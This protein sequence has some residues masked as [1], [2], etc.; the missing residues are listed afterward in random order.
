MKRQGMVWIAG[1]LVVLAGGCGPQAGSS[2]GVASEGQPAPEIAMPLQKGA[3]PVA[4]SSWKGKVVILDFWATWCQPCRQSIPE[5]ERVYAK[6]HAK[7]LEVVGISVD[8]AQT[9]AKVP[10]AVKELKMTYPVVLYT[11]IPD[12]ASKYV[13]EGI[14]QMYLIDKKGNISQSISGFDPNGSNL[15]AKVEALLNE[16]G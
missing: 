7:G 3:A 13:F 9:A 1:A 2:A 10:A 8:E 11:D 5:V 6:Y 15:D 14:P 16:K 12:L 4:L